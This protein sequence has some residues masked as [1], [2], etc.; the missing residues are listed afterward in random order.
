MC[1]ADGR[2]GSADGNNEVPRGGAVSLIGGPPL[3]PDPVKQ[4]TGEIYWLLIGAEL[5]KKPAAEL[6]I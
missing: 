6:S 5:D 4:G 3:H 2:K 1:A